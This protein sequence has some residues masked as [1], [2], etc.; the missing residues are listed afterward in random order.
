MF[1]SISIRSFFLK[2]I[3]FLSHPVR[4]C[5]D[6]SVILVSRLR[7]RKGN[8]LRTHHTDIKKSTLSISGNNNSLDICEADIYRSSISI[9]GQNNRLSIGNNT[10]IYNLTLIIKSDNCSVIIAEGTTFGG[11]NVICM[12]DGNSIHIGKHCMI[13]EGVDIWNSDTHIITIQGKAIDNHKPI[14]IHDHVWLGKDVTVLKG[15]T[16]GKN[17]IVGMKSVVTHDIRPNTINAGVPAV[18][19]RDGADWER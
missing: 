2:A 17:A 3:A 11:G 10:K 13:A 7:I 8:Y 5:S 18:E 1:D 4:F 19:V 9:T 16:I 15:V 12:G 14:A 6:G